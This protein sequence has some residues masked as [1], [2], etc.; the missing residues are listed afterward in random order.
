MCGIAGIATTSGG[1][2]PQREALEAMAARLVHRGPDDDGFHVENG[3]GLGHRR[4]SII[5]VAGG[6]NPLTDDDGLAVL[7]FN[8]EIYNHAELRP[9]LEAEGVRF[10]GHCDAETVLHH[11]AKHGAGGLNDL[12]GMYALAFADLADGSAFLARDRLGIKPLY[13]AHDERGLLFGS[14][15]K[16]ILA[17]GWTPR[18]L[19][20][21]ALVASAPADAELRVVPSPAGPALVYR[22]LRAT[23]TAIERLLTDERAW[24][25]ATR[26]RRGSVQAPTP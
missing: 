26:Y 19:R 23:A 22:D 4:L 24:R 5:D 6:R 11:L 10:R 9:A 25:P 17:A 8:G 12:R 16:A 18:E 14:E 21:E 2:P 1:P 20:P 3:V 15:A 13:W 7:V